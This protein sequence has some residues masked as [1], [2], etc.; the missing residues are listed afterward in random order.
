MWVQLAL[1]LL[2]SVLYVILSQDR[3]EAWVNEA[4]QRAC[5]ANI[6]APTVRKHG[7]PQT[8]CKEKGVSTK[9]KSPAQMLADGFY[10]FSCTKRQSLIVHSDRYQKENKFLFS[11]VVSQYSLL[12]N[13]GEIFR[14]SV[15][16]WFE[17]Q[18]C[19]GE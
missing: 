5:E 18:L 16:Q 9:F 19:F 2:M 10:Y 11:I 8:A 6:I 14:N 1:D 15:S 13:S 3:S 12:R 17:K 7:A 4:P